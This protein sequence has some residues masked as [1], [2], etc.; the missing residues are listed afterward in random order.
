MAAR[1]VVI[2]LCAAASLAGG[3]TVPAGAA[4]THQQVSRELVERFPPNPAATAGTSTSA[5]PSTTATSSGPTAVPPPPRYA[6]SKAGGVSVVWIVLVN[7]LAV[8]AIVVLMGPRVR[9]RWPAIRAGVVRGCLRAWRAGVALAAGAARRIGRAT[10]ALASGFV[11]GYRRLG[12]VAAAV[13]HRLGRVAKAGPGSETRASRGLLHIGADSRVSVV[14]RRERAVAK[15]RLL[16]RHPAN[17]RASST[18]AAAAAPGLQEE[19][20]LALP[21]ATDSPV[22]EPAPSDPFDLGLHLEQLGDL[23]G[24]RAA[25]LRADENGHADAAWRLAKLLEQ[26]S[27]PAGA[28]AAFRRA[29]RR[30]HAG[31]ASDYGVLL[32]ERGDLAGA[33]EAFQRADDR[34]DA[35]GAC[36]LGILLER[37]GDLAGAE[38]AYRRADVRGEAASGVLSGERGD[39][40]EAATAPDP[41][42]ITRRHAVR[43]VLVQVIGRLANLLIGVVVVATIAR[44][45]GVDGNGEWTT[46]MAIAAITGYILEPGL[47]PTAL[48][49]AAAEPSEEPRWLGALLAMRL[50][51][52]ILAAAICF[53]W[54]AVVARGEAMII[55]AGLISLNALSSPVQALAVVFQL[56][57]RNDR[58]IAFMTLN[59]IMWT[60]G[61]LA[62]ALLDG[63]VVALAAVFLATSTITFATQ[64]LYVWRGTSIRFDG[65]RRYARTLI[66]TGLLVGLAGGLTIAYGKVDQVLVLHYDGLRGAGLYGA[67]YSLLD[68]VQFLPMVLMTTVFPI[69]AAAWPA[70]AA[71]ARR[72]VQRSVGYMALVSLAVLAF[73][74][75]AARPLVV[76]LFG[77]DFAPAAGALEVLII[78]FVP[79]CFGYVAGSLA[80]VVGRQGRFVLIAAAGLVFNVVGNVLL[81][82]RYGYLAAAWMTVA[83]EIVVIVPAALTIMRAMGISFDASRLPRAAAAAALMGVCVRLANDAGANVV[84]LGVIAAVVYGA[85][86][87]GIGAITPEDR[88]D[89]F[90]WIRRRSG[91]SS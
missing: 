12:L 64:G 20:E 55:A 61:V 2:G 34:G 33:E 23:A 51:T 30:G 5:S 8:V 26:Q 57:V 71:R 81:V 44:A 4:S 17:A 15:S 75:G 70:D 73:T 14:Q 45:L 85:A 19:A 13:S 43:D 48:R 10:A 79:I 89:L 77:G 40:A 68:R 82:P 6:S 76:L 65:L 31:A 36:N 66:R 42:R 88:A 27:D 50:F 28:E 60:A 67:A 53:A 72:A 90:G 84:L 54:S 24:A 29:A 59:S 7:A 39:L 74:L 32:A 35:I 78:A 56:H 21:A 22:D 91:L 9:R 41:R 25:Y 52:G 16:T 1:A 63:G 38:A 11:R 47:S 58:A 69:V 83:T 37:R 80:L 87:L 3:S 46:L 62:V 49:M 86:A 18:V